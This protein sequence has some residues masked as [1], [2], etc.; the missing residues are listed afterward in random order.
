MPN[1]KNVFFSIIVPVY[2]CEKYLKKTLDSICNQNFH[3]FEVLLI[4][5]GSTD[6]SG[7]ICEDYS[8][9][10][11]KF[12]VIHKGNTG[13]SDT[14]NEGIRKSTGKYLL[15][16]DS[17]DYVEP[18]YLGDMYN[19]IKKHNCD[20]INTG[21]Y[22]EV[23]TNNSN[24][25]DKIFIDEKYYADSDSINE[26]LVYLWDSHML[27]N[28]WNKVYSSK[29]IKDN[30][31]YFPNFNFGEDMWFNQKYLDLVKTFYNSDKCYYHYIKERKGS[32]TS[33]F[34]PNLFNLRIKEYL[35]FNDYFIKHGLTEKEYLEFSSRRFIERVLGCIENICS[36]K[37]DNKSK[38]SKIKL[39]LNDSITREALAHIKPRSLK[40]KVLLVPVKLKSAL[41][42]YFVFNRVSNIRKFSP[43]LFNKLKNRR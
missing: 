15:F 4:D 43:I 38:K 3:L 2:N 5:D 32:L 29:I 6:N 17:D 24:T 39:I 19:L 7:V 1:G 42:T 14:R 12:K 34:N 35:E 11:S 30:N 33:K 31:L 23:E 10:N 26:D 16:F 9:V 8:K 40:I 20:L 13:V 21:F 25:Y 36:S 37:L 27:Y 28:V 18:N 22:S 41:L